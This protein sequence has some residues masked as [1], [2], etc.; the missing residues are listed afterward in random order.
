[1]INKTVHYETKTTVKNRIFSILLV[2]CTTFAFAQ[3]TAIPDANFEQALINLGYDTGSPDGVVPT[4]N[5]NTIA[6]LNVSN[7]N[8]RSLRGIQ[9]FEALVILHCNQNNIS[10]L[11]LHNNHNLKELSCDENGLTRLN[12]SGCQRLEF[13]FCNANQL[14]QLD[15]SN[16][17]E[18]RILSIYSNQLETLSVSNNRQ[19]INLS[20]NN[21]NI[22]TLDVSNNV[23]LETLNFGANNL[24]TIDLKRLTRLE[25]LVCSVNNLTNLYVANNVKLK[26]LL[27]NVN[28]ISLLDLR[29]L[30]SLSHFN[31]SGNRNLS[32]INMHN[33]AN[34]KMTLFDI[35]L[36]S[37]KLF[38]V[39]VDD[40][41]W[42]TANW[43]NKDT[44]TNYY[45]KDC[46][47][48]NMLPYGY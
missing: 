33:N 4:A 12:I 2:V 10:S 42:S 40:A 23:L 8:I 38:C 24:E 3:Q 9:D 6:T 29:N 11:D 45:E 26:F 13:L 47:K 25:M 15:V 28:Q 35:R 34:K 5:I 7:N 20:C 48:E 36:C 43:T 1:M 46:S 22:S 16:N 41:K 44:H 31:A 21:N 17:R 37:P 27:C 30:T 14:T 19:L 39:V 18:L 32:Y